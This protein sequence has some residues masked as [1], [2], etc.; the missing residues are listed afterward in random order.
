MP[1]MWQAYYVVGKLAMDQ[2]YD[3]FNANL[4]FNYYTTCPPCHYITLH[5]SRLVHAN[6]S[7]K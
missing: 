3:G 4:R 2:I 5:E 6:Y 1:L 7:I